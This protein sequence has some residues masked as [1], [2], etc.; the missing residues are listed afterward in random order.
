MTQYHLAIDIGASS[1]RHVLGY[2]E[3]GK[4]RLDEI[5]RFENRLVTRNDCIC[6]DTQTLFR[7]IVSGIARCK[8]VGRIPV[9][10]GIDTW[11]VDFVLLDG[12]D[13]ML[14]DMVAY[15]DSRTNGMDKVLERYVSEQELYRLTGIQK[16][17]FNT[18]YQ[19]LAVQELQ[20]KL[21][22]KA[23]RLLMVPEYFNFLLTGIKKSE[24]TNA[25]T[26]ALVNA[27]TKTWDTGLV[28]RLGL[29]NHIFGELNLPGTQ[30]GNFL[31]EIRQ[32][33]G[34]DC[35]VVL[36]ATH[37]TAS[38]VLSAPI[39]EHSVYLS[40]GTWSL[41]GVENTAPICNEKS[42]LRNITN[43]GGYDY[44]FR[45]LKNI[46]G[47]WIIQSIKREYEDKYSY[48]D[49]CEAA[50]AED[51]FPYRIPVNDNRLL[52]PQSMIHAIKCCCADAGYPEPQTVGQ[53]MAC[54]YNSL[55]ESYADTVKEL[56]DVTGRTYNQICI[57]GGGS[58]D[59]YLNELTAKVC[60][61]TVAAG[62]IEASSIGNLLAQ[63]MGQGIFDTVENARSAVRC[64]FD[65]TKYNG[66]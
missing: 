39:D 29:P 58:R 17:P 11:G 40:S 61:K 59:S 36:P 4:I 9:S 38:A 2:V 49:L 10:L 45:Y 34:F 33:V 47:L 27:Q 50:K 35:Q 22:E 56:Q 8:E 41:V 14:G 51:S 3:N 55:A 26:T 43:E 46:M 32:M 54:V 48:N 37:D 66:R 1:G 7:E 63:M 52:A 5:Y 65:V 25:T 31:P 44:R 16:Q 42:R 20:P 13:Q 30:I 62:P 23:E 24:Y 28:R 15:R 57:V 64:S 60:G 53:L 12:R 6:W 21:L 19:L 18:V